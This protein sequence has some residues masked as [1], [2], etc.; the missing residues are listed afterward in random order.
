MSTSTSPRL[1]VIGAGR[2]G[3]TLAALWQQRGTVQ[4]NQLLC[5]SQ[6][7]AEQ[8]AQF[9]GAGRPLHAFN[10]LLPADVWLLAVPDAQIAACAADL[11]A[12]AI[13][14]HWA[15][16]LVFHCSGF[17]DSAHLH[18]LRDQGWAVASAHPVMS[19]A[20]PQAAVAQFAGSLCGLEGD[21]AALS[22]LRAALPAIGGQCFDVRADAKVLYHAAA[23][24]ASNFTVVLQAIAQSA[25]REAGVP[26]DLVGALN[27]QLLNA[28]VANSLALGPAQAITGPAARGDV[29]VVRAQAE[30]VSAWHPQAGEVY[31]ALSAM[32]ADLASAA[33]RAES[34]P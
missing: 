32:A 21:A 28:T 31:R 13:A 7:H 10:G 27:A 30:V 5:R 18:A 1:S 8:A 23:V 12:Q 29:A 6:V 19:F 2:V 34:P 25:W 24:F 20:S 14:Q 16:A 11:A 3:Q 15:P 33:K 26:N 17:C 9:V 4:V 22:W